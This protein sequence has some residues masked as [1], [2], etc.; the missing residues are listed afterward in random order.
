[1][2]VPGRGPR[3]AARGGHEMGEILGL[4][5]THFPPLNGLDDNMAGI[6]RR[7][8]ADPGL[9]ER[10]RP[11][12]R[13][14]EPLRREWGTDEGKAAGAAHRATLVRQFRHARKVLD[15]FRPDVLVIWGDDQYENFKEGIIPPFC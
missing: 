15:E 12:A 6:L 13:G 9:P 3:R 7:V 11:P 2:H 5:M 8:L 14:P 10:P 1:M 4:G